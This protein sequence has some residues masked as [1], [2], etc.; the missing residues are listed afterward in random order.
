MTS[1]WVGFACSYAPYGA[2][3]W[4]VPLSI[5]IPWGIAL[6]AGLAT[7]MPNSPRQL[8][9]TGKPEEARRQ[10]MRIRRDLASHEVY[11]E[12][13]LM[14]AQIEFEMHREIKSLKEVFRLYRHR[15]LVYVP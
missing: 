10:F 11:E 15:V 12:F 4:R 7:F 5:Q 13:A 1:N 6:F 9:R 14:R 2:I 8:I 3:Q